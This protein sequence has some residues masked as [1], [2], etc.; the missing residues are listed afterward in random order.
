VIR[1]VAGRL[2]QTAITLVLL[3]TAIFFGLRLAPGGPAQSLLT[4]NASA[5]NLA[6]FT[7]SLGLDRPLWGQYRDWLSDLIHGDLGTSYVTGRSVISMME[8]AAPVSLALIIGA[9]VVG[10]AVSVPAGVVAAVHRDTALDKSILGLGLLGTC[11]PNFVLAIALITLFA[12]VL[13]WLPALGIQSYEG[14][15]SSIEGLTLPV[16]SLAASFMAVVIRMTRSAMVEALEQDYI[17]TAE[18][19]LIS[20]RRIH[21]R[22]ALKNALIPVTTIVGIISATLIGGT[23]IVEKVFSMPGLGSMLVDSVLAR[24]YPVVLAVVMLAALVYLIVN[25]IVDLMYGL[26]DPRIRI[27]RRA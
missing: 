19:C 2:A 6:Q 12:V 26:L 27:G 13:G 20:P 9:L 10:V 1:Y 23:V 25:L 18:S 22:L 24:D 4:E 14:L 3:I 5:E 15:G 11:I 17:V 8:R 16:I 7:H 21:Y